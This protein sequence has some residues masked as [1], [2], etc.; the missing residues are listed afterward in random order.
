MGLTTGG[1]WMSWAEWCR[2][3]H[4]RL[5]EVADPRLFVLRPPAAHPSAFFASGQ[6]SALQSFR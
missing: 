1:G 4:E 2:Q 5:L 3:A 6:T